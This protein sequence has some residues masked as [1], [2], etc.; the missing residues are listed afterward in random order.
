MSLIY[1]G[2]QCYRLSTALV[3][4]GNSQCSKML[5]GYVQIPAGTVGPLFLD[6]I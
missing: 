6:G 4:V 3:A 2:G 1:L 5:V